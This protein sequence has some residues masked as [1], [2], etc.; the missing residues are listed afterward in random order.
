MVFVYPSFNYQKFEAFP[1]RKA[2][3]YFLSEGGNYPSLL[4]KRLEIQDFV[5]CL[6]DSSTWQGEGHLHFLNPSRK[7]LSHPLLAIPAEII[8]RLGL[9]PQ[10]LNPITGMIFF[11]LRGE[12]FY[13]TRFK[14]V[15][16][17]GR[18]SKFYLAQHPSDSW[19]DLDGN[20]LIHV[21]M[22]HYNLFFKLAELFTVSIQGDLKHPVY[23]LTKQT[24]KGILRK[25]HFFS[26]DL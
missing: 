23:T 22:R 14:D 6:D 1:L 9:D 3:T 15:Y 10:V 11:K 26:I 25:G 13:L 18:G 21:R 4:V 2:G 8:L 16:S 20:L 5:G 24:N 7:N 17:E 12:R 19:I